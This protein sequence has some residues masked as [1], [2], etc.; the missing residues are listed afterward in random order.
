M[1]GDCYVGAAELPDP[2]NNHGVV[3]CEFAREAL[4]KMKDTTHQM[5]VS[6]GPDTTALDFKDWNSQ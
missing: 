5:E 3:A 4:K 1:V 2:M 6:L